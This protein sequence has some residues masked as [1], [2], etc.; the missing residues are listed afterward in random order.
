MCFRVG[1]RVGRD[2]HRGMDEWV[3]ADTC[4]QVCVG[5][6]AHGHRGVHV[7]N[8]ACRCMCVHRDVQ[9]HVCVCA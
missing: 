7:C 4:V 5:T 6:A 9:V 3:S 8:S 2:A 1:L